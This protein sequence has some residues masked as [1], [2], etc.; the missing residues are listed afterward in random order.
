[1]TGLRILATLDMVRL[2]VLVLSRVGRRSP[3]PQRSAG[4]LRM[5]G[6][7]LG[8]VFAI[9]LALLS[10]HTALA[11]TCHVKDQTQPVG[12]CPSAP[13]LSVLNG[14]SNET[15][16]ISNLFWFILAESGVVFILVMAM[17]F[18]SMARYSHRPGHDE[19][20]KQVYGNRRVEISWTVIPAII[21]FVAFVA[22]VVVMNDINNPAKAA[23]PIN[24]AIGAKGLTIDAIGHQWWWEFRI[25]KFHVVTANEI[26]I[27][28]DT[29]VTVDIT[30]VDV[31]HSFWVP[32]LDRQ[33]DA[34]PNIRTIVYIDA[35]RTGTF[36]GACYEYCGQGHAWMQFRMTVD[37]P[38]NFLKWAR[39]E[40]APPAAPATNLAAAGEGVFFSQSCSVCHTIDGTPATGTV[41]PNLTHVGNRWGI[42]GG[43]L[44]M[45]EK[46]LE[47]W[48]SD[49]NQW[50]EGVQMPSFSLSK[51]DLHA[52]ATYL[53]GLK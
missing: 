26:Q 2:R 47:R 43:V 22:T 14:A 19:E 51:S 46:N 37:T 25:P 52:L 9:G 18:I 38:S 35:N 36:A 29:P 48:I 20:P 49:P 42:A 31:I 15:L 5:C 45:S 39:N 23:G 21:L 12:S 6:A 34:T 16:A 1:M 30:S 7:L 28:V 11:T 13:A 53:I 41:A 17:L 8:L 50:K 4:S 40:A 10:T 3:G 44:V 27:P 33:V 32:Q 24:P